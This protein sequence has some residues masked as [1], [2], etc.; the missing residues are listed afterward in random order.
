MPIVFSDLHLREKS[1]DVCFRVLDEI[2]NLAARGDKRI[3]FCGDFWHIRYAIHVRLLNKVS[4]V[5]RRWDQLGLHVDFVPGNH[6]QIDVEGT[7]ALEVFEAFPRVRVWSEPGVVDGIGFVPH[8]K[9]ALDQ[10]RVLDYAADNGAA[11]IYSHFG[12]RGSMMNS[13][14]ADQEGLDVDSSWPDLILGHYHCRQTGDGW[15]Y[16]GSPYQTNF[17]EAGNRCGCLIDGV[18]VELDVGAPVHHI[19]RWDPAEEADP[20]KN[21]GKP[22]DHVRLDIA[23]TR[24]MI[25]G[26]KF[27]GVLKRYSLEDAQVNIIPVDVAREHRFSLERGETIA[28]AAKRFS[29]ERLAGAD[30]TEALER[31]M[32]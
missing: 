25:V 6:D 27:K 16:V 10:A 9:H 8:R 7:N 4:A 19:L 13:R 15:E 29:A 12:V 22:R 1:E 24:E 26:G 31:W 28:A 17:A 21:P 2:G 23:A 11:L 14:Q 30:H 3:I 18:F 20:P 32:K 5:L